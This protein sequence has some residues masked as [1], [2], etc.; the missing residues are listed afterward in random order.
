MAGIV[1]CG[2]CIN[3]SSHEK[4]CTKPKAYLAAEMEGTVNPD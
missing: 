2:F 1:A 3:Y 4:M